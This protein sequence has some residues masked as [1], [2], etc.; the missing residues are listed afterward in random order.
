MR[1]AV[2]ILKQLSASDIE[3]LLIEMMKVSQ[4]VINL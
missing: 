4:C 2:N 1:N 3:S